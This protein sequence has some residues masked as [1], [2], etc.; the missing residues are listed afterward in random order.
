MADS[1]EEKIARDY[2]S[3]GTADVTIV[4]VDSTRLERNL[5][6]VYQIMSLTDNIIVCVNL[7]DEASKKGISKNYQKC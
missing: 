7:L 3:S 2:I 6:L 1:E 4:I 5:N